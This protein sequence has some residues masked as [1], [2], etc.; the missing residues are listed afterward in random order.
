MAAAPVA[1][2]ESV[3]TLVARNISEF[4]SAVSDSF[5]PLQVSG[6][7]PA[8]FRGLIRGAAVDEV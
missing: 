3:S 2:A 4:R 5:V 8:P 7:G 6:E 1:P